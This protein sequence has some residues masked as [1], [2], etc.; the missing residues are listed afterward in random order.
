MLDVGCAK[1]CILFKVAD[2]HLMMW[3]I[4]I[5]TSDLRD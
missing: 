1:E 2:D 5:V 4:H 3:G